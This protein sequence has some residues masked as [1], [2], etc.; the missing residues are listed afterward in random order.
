M[1]WGGSPRYT[2]STQKP[3]LSSTLGR[4]PRLRSLGIGVNEMSWALPSG[5]AELR[6]PGSEQ[7]PTRAETPEAPG[8]PG[9]SQRHL[10]PT[11]GMEPAVTRIPCLGTEPWPDECRRCSNQ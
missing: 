6:A 8:L 5:D 7:P 2:A 3:P 1:S 9:T 10:T 11:A 4:D